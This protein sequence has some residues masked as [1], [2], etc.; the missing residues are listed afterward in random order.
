VKR[1]ALYAPE[2]LFV[3]ERL[4]KNADKARFQ[5]STGINLGNEK[6]AAFSLV[7]KMITSQIQRK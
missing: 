7:C 1:D 6:D 2:I 5:K 3:V 4:N